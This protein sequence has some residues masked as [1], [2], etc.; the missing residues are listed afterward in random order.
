MVYHSA[1]NDSPVEMCGCAVLPLRTKARGPAA[2][3]KDDGPDLADEVLTYFKPNMLYRTF[4][5]QGPGDRLLI[6][7]VLYVHLCLKRI[8]KQPKDKAAK[9]LFALAQEPFKVPGE[10]GFIL[11]GFLPDPRDATEAELWRSYVRQLREEIGVRLLEL[12]YAEPE[13]GGLP[14]KWWMMF[15]KRKFLNKSFEN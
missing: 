13:E 11:P 15:A 14:S 6:Y 8:A 7:G 10:P 5:V 3:K 9:T 12:A 2:P 1:Y 4:D